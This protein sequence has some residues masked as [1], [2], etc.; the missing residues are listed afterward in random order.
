MDTLKLKIAGA[1]MFS[2]AFWQA[3]SDEPSMA[4]QT[5]DEAPIVS[6]TEDSPEVR[7]AKEAV[8]QL[9][10]ESRGGTLTVKQKSVYPSE[11]R[12]TQTPRLHIVNFNEGG[13]AVVGD[14]TDAY[15]VYAMSENGEFTA[16]ASDSPTA[17]FL[18]LAH[19]YQRVNSLA[20][21][22]DPVPFDPIIQDY[23]IVWHG[24]HYCRRYTTNKYTEKVEPLLTTQWHQRSPYN[25]FCFTTDGQQAVAGCV[26]LAMAQIMAYHK[27]PNSYGS[28]TYHWENINLNWIA[29]DPTNTVAYLIS[30]IGQVTGAEYGV[31]G[32]PVTENRPIGGF[33]EFGYTGCVQS[34]YNKYIACRNISEGRPVYMQGVDSN[35]NK[36]HAWC[37]DG[38]N[39]TYYDYKYVTDETGVFCS[40]GMRNDIYIHCNWGWGFSNGYCYSDVFK[41]DDKNYNT[42]LKIIY[43]IY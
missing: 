30:D 3:C 21:G 39:A 33:K 9:R 13:Y 2:A 6:F 25:K 41:V 20:I 10:G 36:G 18:T 14:S 29:S 16:D 15:R 43:D 5:L 8:I 23:V 19:E 32:S 38:F 26:P 22:P 37:I 4:P 28:H 35:I 27:K 7:A 40:T 1:L 31:T 17:Y 11:S 12:S 42:N 24:N 34:A